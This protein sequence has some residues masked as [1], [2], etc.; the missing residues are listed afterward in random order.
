M[1]CL[2]ECYHFQTPTWTSEVNT[3]VVMKQPIRILLHFNCAEPPWAPPLHN[4]DNIALLSPRSE[5]SE[6]DCHPWRWDIQ[7]ENK[8]SGSMPS[9]AACICR[10]ACTKQYQLPEHPLASTLRREKL[11][12]LP[13]YHYQGFISSSQLTTQAQASYQKRKMWQHLY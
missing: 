7:K 1:W 10:R 8:S 2:I 6:N 9:S 11:S 12:W 5:P 4:A 3:D 13:A